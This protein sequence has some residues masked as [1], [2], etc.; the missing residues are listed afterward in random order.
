M[1]AI[2]PFVLIAHGLGYWLFVH[3][4]KY[5][6]VTAFY[7]GMPGGLIEA[8]SLGEQNG[9]NVTIL[10]AQHF[11]RIVM[12]VVLVPLLFYVFSGQVVGSSSGQAPSRLPTTG[13]DIVG[14][15]ALA[16]VGMVFGSLPHVM[17]L[18]M[19]ALFISF[20]PG[21]VAEMGLVALSLN[22]SPVIVSVHH[23]LR[24]MATV[25][26]AGHFGLNSRQ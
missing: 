24:I 15:A 20:A 2:V 19:S 3:V 10:T 25:F 4:G 7:C 22:L 6:R 16:G 13:F 12:V 14:I 17:P 9:A 1:L 26:I 23:L 11:A 8:I 5:D 18:S 21:G